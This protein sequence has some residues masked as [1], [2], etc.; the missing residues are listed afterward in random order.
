VK[1]RRTVY[2]VDDEAVIRAS[3]GSLL[4]ARGDLDT[5][6]FSSGHAL[7]REIDGL[8]PGCVILDLQL[9]GE[10]GAEVM[11]V[12]APRSD[13][14]TIVVTGAGDIAAAV[15]AFRA[16]AVDFLYKPYEI[17]PLMD[18]IDRA[19]YLLDHGE[20]PPQA[21]EQARMAMARLTNEEADL[22]QRLIGGYTNQQ[23]AR[24]AGADE[25]SVQMLRARLLASLEVPS[26]LAA[27]RTAMIAGQVAG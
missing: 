16:G 15:G 1:A 11:E 22:L 23:I 19:L 5:R 17:K 8:T 21:V 24:D 27:I 20:E 6:E 14:R 2:I 9:V 10:S 26:L 7:L 12:L 25:R 3:T 13:F 18:A 4:Q